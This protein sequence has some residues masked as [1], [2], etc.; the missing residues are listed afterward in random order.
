MAPPPPAAPPPLA[1]PLVWKQDSTIEPKKFYKLFI[2]K[3]INNFKVEYALFV[4]PKVRDYERGIMH[5]LSGRIATVFVDN[6]KDTDHVVLRNILHSGIDKELAKNLF[7]SLIVSELEKQFSITLQEI[8]KNNFDALYRSDTKP[9]ASRNF[10]PFRVKPQKGGAIEE[11]QD[12]ISSRIEEH[13]AWE[14]AN[15]AYN[16]L[17]PEHQVIIPGP[18]P[19]PINSILDPINDYVDAN[20]DPEHIE[21]ARN[22]VGLLA[23]D[24]LEESLHRNTEPFSRIMPLYKK[25]LPHV[26]GASL[27]IIARADILRTI[28]HK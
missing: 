10:V 14:N 28:L 23:P 22:A 1:E 13:L 24:E 2:E 26:G 3:K 15:S 17:H 25:A 11:P 8:D 19:P 27:P 16:E 20:G 18:G 4:K 5:T 7:D 9:V 12:P 6:A 21:E